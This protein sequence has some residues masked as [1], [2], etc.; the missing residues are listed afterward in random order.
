MQRNGSVPKAGADR[1][2]LFALIRALADSGLDLAHGAVRMAASEG[3]IVLRRLAARLGLLL[4]GL[5]VAA[6]GLVL[7]LG[8]LALLLARISGMEPWL[9]LA[10]VGAATLGAGAV[11]AA[12]AL[13][14][15][16][17]PDLAFP[18]TLAELQADVDTLRG[19]RT[20]RGEE[21]AP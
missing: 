3:R 11:L 17:E 8:G 10:I 7:L 4:G 21:E 20:C 18:A 2:G 9:A 1:R 12:G 16:S 15:L 19:G 6:S 13:R 5:L 14:R